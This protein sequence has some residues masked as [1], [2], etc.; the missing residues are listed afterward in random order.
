MSLKI[1]LVEDN[2]LIRDDLAEYL[3]EMAGA[4]IVGFS[5]TE[6]EATAWLTTHRSAWDLAVVDL[7]LLQGNGL[8]V[9]TSCSSRETRQKVVVLTNYAT[10]AMRERCLA[11]GAD[12]LFDKSSELEEFTRYAVNEV[13]RSTGVWTLPLGI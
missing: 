9:V 3:E 1:Y 8:G 4:K 7:F 5:A 13:A 12:A 6:S 2:P 10:P 11:A